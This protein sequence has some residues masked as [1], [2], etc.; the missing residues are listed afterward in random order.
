MPT[1]AQRNSVAAVVAICCAGTGAYLGI[2]GYEGLRTVAYRDASPKQIWTYCFG[3]TQR[4]DGAAVR[5][6]DKATPAE[7]KAMLAN[8]LAGGFVPGVEKCI[9]RDM[10]VK[11]EAAFVSLA[12]NIGIGAFCKSLVARKWNG[13]AWT[14]ACAAMRLYVRSGDKV[15]PGLVRRRDGESELCMEGLQ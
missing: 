1:P 15:L 8:R 3:E 9:T 13:G 12:Y 5:K 4:T 10:P 7:C 2:G 6:G 11:V 14:E